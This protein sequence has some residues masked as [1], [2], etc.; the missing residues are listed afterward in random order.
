LCQLFSILS[1]VLEQNVSEA[2]I[3]SIKRATLANAKR[4]AAALHAKLPGTQIEDCAWAASMIGTLVAG[5]WPGAHPAPVVAKVLAMPEFAGL[6]PSVERDL[7]RAA[8]A[9]LSSITR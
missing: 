8:L 6:K 7:E 2:T 4:I 3:L 1:T 5:M 9:L